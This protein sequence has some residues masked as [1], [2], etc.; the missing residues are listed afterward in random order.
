MLTTIVTTAPNVKLQSVYRFISSIVGI[1]AKNEK[2]IS[3]EITT[4]SLKKNDFQLCVDMQ[5]LRQK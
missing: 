3:I 1:T 5:Y 2:A 4:V